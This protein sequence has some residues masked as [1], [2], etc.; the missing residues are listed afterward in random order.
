MCDKMATVTSYF[1]D[2]LQSLKKVSSD[3]P[4][5]APNNSS[6]SK[7]TNSPHNIN[8][9]EQTTS[10]KNRISLLESENRLLEGDIADK[11]TFIET[12]LNFNKSNIQSV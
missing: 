3:N 1:M 2:E 8:Y 7:S 12:F 11:Q 4:K 6:N 5:D 9:F 10:L